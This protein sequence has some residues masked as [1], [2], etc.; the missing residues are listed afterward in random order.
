MF[1]E[2]LLYVRHVPDNK[3]LSACKWEKHRCRKP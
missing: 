2:Q 3:T 1:I